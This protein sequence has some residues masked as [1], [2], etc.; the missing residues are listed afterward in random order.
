[1]IQDMMPYE[2]AKNSLMFQ[3]APDCNQ[4][5]L[6]CELASIAPEAEGEPPAFLNKAMTYTCDNVLEEISEEERKVTMING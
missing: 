5:T 6:K 1:M 2:D 3:L 4:M